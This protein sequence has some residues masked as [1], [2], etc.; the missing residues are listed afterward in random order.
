MEERKIE[1]ISLDELLTSRPEIPKPFFLRLDTQDSKLE[2]LQGAKETLNDVVGVLAE[3]AFTPI[4]E[5]QPLFGEINEFLNSAG[6]TLMDIYKGVELTNSRERVGARA[7]R[8]LSWSDALFFK[9][10]V[11]SG[12]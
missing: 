3:V 11:N 4:Y 7:K 9:S 8:Q 10:P 1:T 6:Y 12:R 2:I 5:N